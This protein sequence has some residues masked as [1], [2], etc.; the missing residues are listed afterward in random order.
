[1]DFNFYILLVSLI[2]GAFTAFTPCVLPILP[3]VLGGSF[4]FGQGQNSKYK[5]SRIILSLIASVFAFTLL[6]KYS[7]ALIDVS[8]EVLKAFSGVIIILVAVFTFYPVLFAKLMIATGIKTRI[9][10][11]SSNAMQKVSPNFKDYI[12]GLSLGPIFSSCSPTYFFILASVLPVS[13][14]IG[15]IYLLVYCVGLAASLY[16]ISI[17]GEALL[18]KL[19]QNPNM[20]NIFTKVIAVVLLLTGISIIFG[21][22]KYLQVKTP[23]IKPLERIEG[24]LLQQN[25]EMKTEVKTETKVEAKTETKVASETVK[26]LPSKTII[27]NP[28]PKLLNK[29][30]QKDGKTYAPEFSDTVGSIDGAYTKAD[31]ITLSNTLSK[32]KVVIVYFWTFGCINCQRSLPSLNALYDKY[33]DKGLEVIGVHTPEFAYE[34]KKEN[35]QEA[36]LKLGVKFPVIMDNNYSVWNS[37][38]NSYWPR[39]Y[40]IL[41]SGEIVFD[42]SGEGAYEEIDNIVSKIIG[43]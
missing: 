13:F 18:Q 15:S 42:H 19:I 6:L 29:V 35:I 4:N 26:P 3:I 21:Y 36:M 34:G 39:K 40:I 23:S 14:F 22:D 33:H 16:T 8:P 27:N 11:L 38:E 17:F 2:A 10:R 37:Y 30:N 1:M 12:L 43:Q 41:P 5:K 7:T 32:N 20:E 25:M 24:K 9:D 28:A 31:G